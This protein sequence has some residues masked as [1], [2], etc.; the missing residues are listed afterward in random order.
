MTCNKG[1]EDIFLCRCDLKMNECRDDNYLI[2]QSLIKHYL[3]ELQRRLGNSLLSVTLFGSVARG[4]ATAN[5]DIDLLTLVKKRTYNIEKRIIKVNVE[6]FNWPEMASLR[7]RRIQTKIY[8][9][10]KTE[11]ELRENPLILLDISEDGKILYDPKGKMKKIL[12]KL[13]KK[14][15]ELGAEKIVLKN[16]KGYWDLKP[17][18]KPGELVEI[19]L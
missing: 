13:K 7:E 15:K 8:N 9:I 1:R 11:A 2:Y 5:S 3:Q 19:K 12:E 6:S 4:E 14:L 17:D 16:G 18:W 10:V